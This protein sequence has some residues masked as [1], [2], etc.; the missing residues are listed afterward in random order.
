MGGGSSKIL[1]YKDATARCTDEEL[2]RLKAIFKTFATKPLPE[3]LVP[4]IIY[5]QGKAP[6]TS[7]SKEKTGI[8]ETSFVEDVLDVGLPEKMARRFFQC[9]NERTG[10]SRLPW[11]QFVRGMVLFSKGTPQERSQ[12]LITF[13]DTK[14]KTSILREEMAKILVEDLFESKDRSPDTILDELFGKANGSPQYIDCNHFFQ[15]AQKNKERTALT[16]WIFQ[17]PK[18]L[19]KI[20]PELKAKLNAKQKPTKSQTSPTPTTKQPA[21]C[22]DL[23]QTQDLEATYGKLIEVGSQNGTICESVL[24][25]AL[26]GLPPLLLEKAIS[27][28]SQGHKSKIE[29]KDFICAICSCWRTADTAKNVEFCFKLYDWDDDG[30]LDEPELVSMIGAMWSIKFPP[31]PQPQKA[32]QTTPDAQAGETDGK[33]KSEVIEKNPIPDEK[34]KKA[35]K[36]ENNNN[37][38]E[39]DC[40][41]LDFTKELKPLLDKSKGKLKFEEFSKWFWSNKEVKDF[42][43]SMAEL[44][45]YELGILP[46]DKKLEMKIIDHHMKDFDEKKITKTGPYFLIWSKWWDLWKNSTKENQLMAIDNSSLLSS[47]SQLTLRPGLVASTDYVL[48]PPMAWACVY[49]WYGGGPVLQRHAVSVSESKIEV[50]LYPIELTLYL[51]S[52]PAHIKEDIMGQLKAGQLPSRTSLV[53]TTIKT[54]DL[55]AIVCS[56]FNRSSSDL[57]QNNVRLWELSGGSLSFINTTSF[58]KTLPELGLPS[59]AKMIVELRDEN[60]GMWFI[61]L[62]EKAPAPKSVV[63][64]TQGLANLGNTCYM[65][66]SI[67]VLSNM[68]SVADYFV[69]KKYELEINHSNVLGMNGEVATQFG[70]LLKQIWNDN[71][72]TWGLIAPLAFKNT[73]SKHNEQFVG[74]RQQDAQEFLAFLLDGLHEDLNRILQKPIPPEIET[75]GRTDSDIAAEALKNYLSRNQSI[76]TDLFV[77]QFRSVTCCNS[78]NNK[79]TKFEPFRYVNLPLPIGRIKMLMIPVYLSNCDVPTRYGVFIKEGSTIHDL[80]VELSKLCNLPIEK[81]VIADLYRSYIFEIL[82]DSKVLENNVI[83]IA[84]QVAGQSRFLQNE[85]NKILMKKKKAADAAM[86][87]LDNAIE[88]KENKLIAEQEAKDKKKQ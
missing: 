42:F 32:K 5:H 20:S 55:L 3:E 65:N 76:I 6:E 21:M 31:P 66:A 70:K 28:T 69:S 2:Q 87:K 4:K 1:S 44:S 25:S 88:E 63:P 17:P 18:T 12:F 38:K 24:R 49:N 40:K 52:K 64:G 60:T 9:F 36:P 7:K 22:F 26:P 41:H 13:Y 81:M 77:G 62:S 47:N 58:E 23:I 14:T 78:C 10:S 84:F 19:D 57:N 48:L 34:P 74:F 54:R 37:I 85:H 51:K 53:S 46:S 8:T 80:K 45:N 29:I 59:S 82:P 39:Y 75:E 67:Q 79:S 43:A 11:K 33:G 27:A 83:P 72:S 73:C 68:P 61:P 35:L 50:E 86:K 71:P 15:W 30:K 56:L 16:V